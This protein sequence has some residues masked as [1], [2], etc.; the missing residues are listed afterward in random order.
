MEK[1]LYIILVKQQALQILLSVGENMLLSTM[2]GDILTR[3]SSWWRLNRPTIKHIPFQK[4][5]LKRGAPGFF[6]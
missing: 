6:N 3:K 4:K 2:K 5:I 1:L